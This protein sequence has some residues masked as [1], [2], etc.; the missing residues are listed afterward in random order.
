M[1]PAGSQSRIATPLAIAW[2]LLPTTKWYV[3]PPRQTGGLSRPIAGMSPEAL[4]SGSGNFARWSALGFDVVG[5]VRAHTEA[6]PAF[7]IVRSTAGRTVVDSW[8]LAWT[9][10][11]LMF[12]VTVAVLKMFAPAPTTTIPE[13]VTVIVPPALSVLSLQRT[14]APFTAQPPPTPTVPFATTW[15]TV[16]DDVSR[17]CVPSVMTTSSARVVEVFLTWIL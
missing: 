11:F 17:A 8:A 16:I 9:P 3:S 13:I 4:G 1:T 12:P 5:H 7:V 15:L 6:G 14:W 2:P 10:W